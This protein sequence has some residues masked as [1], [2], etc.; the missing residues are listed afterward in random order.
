MDDLAGSI[1]IELFDNGDKTV[2]ESQSG[3]SI[4]R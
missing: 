3:A 4:S 1:F 2:V